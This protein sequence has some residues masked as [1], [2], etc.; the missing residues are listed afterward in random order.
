VNNEIPGMQGLCWSDLPLS[1]EQIYNL[2]MAGV[3]TDDEED[4][5]IENYDDAD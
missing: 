1:E 2:Q 3:F 4:D 5:L